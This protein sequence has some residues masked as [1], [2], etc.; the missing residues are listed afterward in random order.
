MGK[1]QPKNI[2]ANTVIIPK[3]QTPKITKLKLLSHA[4]WKWK[5]KYVPINDLQ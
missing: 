1:N 5:G 3:F 4:D 2:M